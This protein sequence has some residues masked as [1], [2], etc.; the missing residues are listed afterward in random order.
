MYP[1]SSCPPAWAGDSRFPATPRSCPPNSCFSR[2]QE[3]D[4]PDYDYFLKKWVSN[5]LKMA[6]EHKKL[7][8]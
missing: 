5:A 2:P 3:T 1:T 6:Q 8:P 7:N 4:F